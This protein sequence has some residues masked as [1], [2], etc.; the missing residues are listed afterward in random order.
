MFPA[1]INALHESIDRR[2]TPVLLGLALLIAVGFNMVVKVE[3]QPG[4]SK[5]ILLGTQ[6]FVDL[7]EAVPF[8][9]AMELRVAGGL[10]M[11]LSMLAAVP[12]LTATLEKGWFELLLAK[13]TPRWEVF[14]GRFLGGVTLYVITYMIAILPLAFRLWW[15]TDIATW[16]LVYALLFQTLSFAALLAIAAFATLAQK[17]IPISVII[18]LAVWTISPSLA[19]RQEIYYPHITS[20][21]GRGIIDLTYIIFPKCS[22]IDALSAGLIQAQFITWWW[23]LWSTLIFAFL[24]LAYTLWR[25]EHKSL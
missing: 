17:G 10:W 8:I 23:P 14:M 11:I 24:V 18:A 12:L 25:L 22:E 21:L 13:A 15:Q 9:L 19:Q 3:P 20:P 4:C 5:I 16:M 2:M 6:K 7:Q 1:Y